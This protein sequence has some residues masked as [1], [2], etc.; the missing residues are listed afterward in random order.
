MGGVEIDPDA[1]FDTAKVIITRHRIFRADARKDG[2]VE[3]KAQQPS[4]RRS[5]LRGSWGRK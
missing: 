5:F 4:G 1:K 3:N 2:R